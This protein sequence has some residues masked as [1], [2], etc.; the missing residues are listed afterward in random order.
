ME[1]VI[2]NCEGPMVS[3]KVNIKANAAFLL[4]SNRSDGELVH[5][6]IITITLVMRADANNESSSYIL[7]SQ[8]R[9]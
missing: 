9:S 1:K 2:K 3:H 4:H 8:L 6:K 7:H 5:L